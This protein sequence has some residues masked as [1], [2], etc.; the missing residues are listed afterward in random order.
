MNQYA[1]MFGHEIPYILA[2]IVWIRKKFTFRFFLNKVA[3]ILR[4][5]FLHH[6]KP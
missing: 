4:L 1:Y 2:V 3:F 5:K 6:F